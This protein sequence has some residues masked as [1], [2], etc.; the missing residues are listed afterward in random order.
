MIKIKSKK[1]IAM[2]MVVLTFFSTFSPCIF[3]T[4]INSAN[5]EKKRK[6]RMASSILGWWKKNNSNSFPRN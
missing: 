3:A 2:L 5:L 4:E 6:S 1:I